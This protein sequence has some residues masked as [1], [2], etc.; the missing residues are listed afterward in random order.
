M[1][2]TISALALCLLAGCSHKNPQATLESLP[3][4]SNR[5]QQELAQAYFRL[6][7]STSCNVIL[8]HQ[9]AGEQIPAPMAL[10]KECIAQDIA[11][12]KGKTLLK[13]P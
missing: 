10:L 1:K 13:S 9:I 12:S 11:A 5:A 7:V 6:G 4:L 3:N 8:K 2:Q